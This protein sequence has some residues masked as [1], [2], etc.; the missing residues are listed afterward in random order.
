[1]NPQISPL[2]FKAIYTSS[3]QTETYAFGW[4]SMGDTRRVAVPS[5]VPPGNHNSCR[6]TWLS[7][8]EVKDEI[9]WGQQLLGGIQLPV[10]RSSLGLTLISL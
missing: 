8:W 2:T 9:P 4:A 10:R 6:G 5:S 1:M 3:F 7:L